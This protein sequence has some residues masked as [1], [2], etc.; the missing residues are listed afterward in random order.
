MPFTRT[1]ILIAAVSAASA[2]PTGLPISPTPTDRTEPEAEP[3]PSKEPPES[4]PVHFSFSGEIRSMRG[5]FDS[6]HTTTITQLSATAEARYRRLD[7]S[8]TPTWLDTETTGTGS[9]GSSRAGSPFFQTPGGRGTAVR[10]DTFHSESGM[11][12]TYLEAGF[13]AGRQPEAGADVRLS[14]GLKV[15]TANEHRGLGTGETDVFAHIEFTRWEGNNVGALR[16]GETFMGDPAGVD[17][18][19][20]LDLAFGVGRRFHLASGDTLEP[21][22]WLRGREAVLP[23]MSD[24]AELAMTLDYGHERAFFTAELAGGLT[25]GAP[26]VT[27]AVGAGYDF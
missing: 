23:G 6:P 19:D 20:S 4:P 27:V 24:P 14:A 21:R 13:L 22:L 1:F 18:R 17:Y 3:G 25:P 11:G 16:I 7:F 9:A 5:D 15:P 10:G 26:D 2:A 12:D 8:V